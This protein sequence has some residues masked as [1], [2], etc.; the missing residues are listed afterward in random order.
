MTACTV[1]YMEADK[2]AAGRCKRERVGV[3][4]CNFPVE[5]H[6]LGKWLTSKQR[7]AVKRKG[8]IE[9][10]MR[11]N[12]MSKKSFQSRCSTGEFL[13]PYSNRSCAS[14]SA[15]DIQTFKLQHPMFFGDGVL[16]TFHAECSVPCKRCEIYTCDVRSLNS[17]FHAAVVR[18][19]LWREYMR[20]CI[21][22]DII[23]Y[24]LMMYTSK[25]IS[26]TI[27][28]TSKTHIFHILWMMGAGIL[29]SCCQDL[30]LAK[31]EWHDIGG[32][33]GRHP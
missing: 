22:T 31:A 16:K 32:P 1:A 19:A 13:W 4:H 28:R 15:H 29:V 9:I 2:H 8:T 30:E 24:V 14:K 11:D 21:C 17:E 18:F 7:A 6:P 10:G 3:L 20:A 27:L 23:E 12:L 26:A 5:K 25:N 33:T